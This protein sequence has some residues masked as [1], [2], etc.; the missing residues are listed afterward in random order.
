MTHY[1]ALIGEKIHLRRGVNLQVCHSPGADPPMVFIHGGTGNRF[2]FRMQYEFAQTQ[3]WEVL[4]YDLA[5]NGE[6]S[7]YSRYSIGRHCRDL[8]RL[9]QQFG[10]DLPVLCCHSYGVP[11]GLEFIQH[12]PAKAIVAI[13]GGTHD[14]APWWEI[15][16]MK[17]MAWGGRYLLH[18]P[19]VQTVNKFLSTSYRHSVMERFFAENPAPTDFDAYKG[20]EIFWDYNFFIR[21]PLPKNLHIP[22][23]IITAGKDPMFTAKMGDELASHFDDG[24]HLHYADAGHL[25]M[26]ECAE[27]VN[28]A[29]ANWLNQKV[30]SI[31]YSNTIKI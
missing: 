21:H 17:F 2:N 29:I 14:L 27:L 28:E 25:V 8:H 4:A 20:L 10:I 3:G 15:P 16:L 5:G 1:D 19:G 13:A 23:L 18:L 6:S 22:A 7:R 31:Q 11:I 12:Y 26:A 24:T 30:L 9:L